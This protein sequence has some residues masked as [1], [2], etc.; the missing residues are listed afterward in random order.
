[1]GRVA[2]VE[3]PWL[4]ASSC[5]GIAELF[6]PDIK[7]AIFQMEPLRWAQTYL[8]DNPRHIHEVSFEEA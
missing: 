7:A 3:D 6:Q 5:G 8:A 2:V 1:V 4:C